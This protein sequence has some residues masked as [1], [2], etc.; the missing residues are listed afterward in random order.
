MYVVVLTLMEDGFPDLIEKLSWENS[1]VA[2][3]RDAKNKGPTASFP[4]RLG[5]R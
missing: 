2:E 3:P 5:I 1:A 4:R